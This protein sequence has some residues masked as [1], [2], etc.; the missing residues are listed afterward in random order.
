LINDLEEEAFIK[1]YGHATTEDM[2]IMFQLPHN[3]N[4]SNGN[5]RIECVISGE[6]NN[7]KIYDRRKILI[8]RKKDETIEKTIEMGEWT[9]LAVNPILKVLE[10]DL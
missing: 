9:G 6:K 4:K 2:M 8:D 3:Y 7:K 10:T 5:I 1:N